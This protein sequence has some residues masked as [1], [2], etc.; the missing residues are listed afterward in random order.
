ML[1]FTF[2]GV[3]V[4]AQTWYMSI[5]KG[6]VPYQLNNIFISAILI[7]KPEKGMKT[8]WKAYKNVGFI[9]GTFT[10]YTVWPDFI[11]MKAFD[12]YKMIGMDHVTVQ[13]NVLLFKAYFNIFYVNTELNEYL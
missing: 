13:L 5:E 8:L 3:H 7:L 4:L 2:P 9:K 11:K 1:Y 10:E 6:W 12:M